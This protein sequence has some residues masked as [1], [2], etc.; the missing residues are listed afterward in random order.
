[1]ESLRLRKEIGETLGYFATLLRYTD[2]HLEEKKFDDAR[3]IAQEGLS[4][5]TKEKVNFGII[6]FLQMLGKVEMTTGNLA[7]AKKNY[8]EALAFAEQFSFKS[9]VYELHLAIAQVDKL[10]GDYESAFDH[11]EKSVKIKEEVVNYQSNTRLKSIQMFTRIESAQRETELERKKNEE[12]K[13]AY[14]IIEERNKDITDS[15]RYAKRIQ[16][17]F[18][19]NDEELEELLGEHFVLFLPRDIVSGDFYW[20]TGVTTTRSNDA[21]ARMKVVAAVDCTGHG[22]P[23]AFMSILGNMLIN[24]T[25]RNPDVNSPAEA[26]DYLNREL[27]KNLKAQNREETIRDGMDLSMIAIDPANMKMHFA[28]ANNPVYFVRDGI[29]TELKGDKQAI[30]GSED[31]PKKPFTGRSVSLKKGDCVYLLTDGFADQFGGPRG[32]KFKY[33]QLQ[34]QLV[35]LHDRPMKEQKQLLETIFRE[36]K[37]DLGQVD[38]VLI[39]GIRVN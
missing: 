31:I 21:N 32:K 2:L 24:Q 34:E 14:D 30:S 35:S 29:L 39:I 1:E 15:I 26:L 33:R 12:L 11:F 38:D 3:R 8:E 28:A 23:G 17:G 16:D 37:G 7:A 10:G 20:A 25:I 19:P 4:I 18:L 36:W 6:R 27:P 22:V 5:A 13:A 9:I